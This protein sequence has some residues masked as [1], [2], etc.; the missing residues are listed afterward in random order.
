MSDPMI[1]RSEWIFLDVFYGKN[2]KRYAFT[3]L[4]QTILGSS[5]LSSS[6]VS[7]KKKK[8]RSSWTSWMATIG[9]ESLFSSSHLRELRHARRSDDMTRYV[10]AILVLVFLGLVLVLEHNKAPDGPQSHSAFDMSHSLSNV[11]SAKQRS[12]RAI[13]RQVGVNACSGFG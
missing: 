5:H 8:N 7:D 12:H 6:A 9:L 3:L 10:R 2:K 11:L 1:V 4:D 13:Q